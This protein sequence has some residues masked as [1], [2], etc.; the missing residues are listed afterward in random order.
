[1][2]VLFNE[3]SIRTI[4][5]TSRPMTYQIPIPA[6]L[7]GARGG[8]FDVVTFVVRQPARSKNIAA[9]GDIRQLGIGLIRATLSVAE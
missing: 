9:R 7:A 1:V 8:L 2:D 3:T 5:L 4:D 6:H